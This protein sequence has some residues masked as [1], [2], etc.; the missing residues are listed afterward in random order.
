MRCILALATAAAVWGACAAPGLASVLRSA[1]SGEAVERLEPELTDH[2]VL[3]RLQRAEALQAFGVTVTA[4]DAALVHVSASSEFLI[5]SVLSGRVSAGRHH[6]GPGEALVAILSSGKVEAYAFDAPHLVGTASP[7]I[8]AE[9]AP[10]LPAIQAKR[11]WATFFGLYE[12]TGVNAAAPVPPA[13]EALRRPLLLSPDLVALRRSAGGDGA[14]LRQAVAL[15]FASRVAGGD[16]DAAARLID[17]APFLV[18]GVGWQD[19]RLAFGRSLAGAPGAA[20][21][22]GARI[23]SQAADQVVFAGD[24][25]RTRLGLVKREGFYFVTSL[26][27]MP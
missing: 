6:A 23:E 11:R 26:E 13:M 10:A 15:Q 9:M 20:S 1:A 4:D 16:L 19:A 14:R 7:A 18:A 17:P 22:A 27:V 25:G 24:A 8:A 21:L 3:A 12:P 2:A 5:F